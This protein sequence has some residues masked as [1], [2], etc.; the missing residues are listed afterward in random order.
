[1]A[2]LFNKLKERV[3]IWRYFDEHGKRRSTSEI[4]RPF[5]QI[6]IES[7]KKGL[8]FPIIDLGAA[9]INNGDY[10]QCIWGNLYKYNGLRKITFYGYEF[11]IPADPAPLLDAI[12]G[13]DWMTPKLTKATHRIKHQPMLYNLIHGH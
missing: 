13:T 10:W 8:V 1:M 5:G 4:T 12:Y 7:S 11:N 6:F 9:W 2:V 3:K